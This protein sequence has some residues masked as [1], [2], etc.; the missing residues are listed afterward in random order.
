M[1][2]VDEDTLID[3]IYSGYGRSS[4]RSLHRIL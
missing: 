1:I 4:W 3:G 2:E